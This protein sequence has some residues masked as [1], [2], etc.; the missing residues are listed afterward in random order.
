MFIIIIMVNLCMSFCWTL[1]CR[2]MFVE[3][4]NGMICCRGMFAEFC[5]GMV[6]MSPCLIFQPLCCRGMIVE[7]CSGMINVCPFIF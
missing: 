5:N 2:G 7:F 6:N 3:F 1:C 4:C